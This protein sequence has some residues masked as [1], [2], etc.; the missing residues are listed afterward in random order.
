M[1][2]IIADDL[3]LGMYNA[4]RAVGKKYPMVDIVR[5]SFEERLFDGR[6]NV[7]AIKRMD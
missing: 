7:F 2:V 4:F 1:V 5:L 6:G 3:R